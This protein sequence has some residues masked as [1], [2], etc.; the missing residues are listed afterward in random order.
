MG[1]LRIFFGMWIL[2]EIRDRTDAE[3]FLRSSTPSNDV[4]TRN[5]THKFKP[6]KNICLGVS[7]LT[8]SGVLSFILSAVF[9][10]TAFL[11]KDSFVGSLGHVTIT[12]VFEGRKTKIPCPRH[13]RQIKRWL[14]DPQ[15]V[16]GRK[17]AARSLNLFTC[18]YDVLNCPLKTHNSI[19]F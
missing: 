1:V 11:E 14:Q 2:P 10:H 17:I 15:V 13:V 9:V 5:Q 19:S 4:H 16:D 6:L 8:W 3:S 7:T 12:P 18:P